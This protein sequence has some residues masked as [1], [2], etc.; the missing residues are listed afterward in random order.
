MTQEKLDAL[1]DYLIQE[2]DKPG[3]TLNLDNEKEAANFIDFLKDTTSITARDVNRAM[4][5]LRLQGKAAT[6][7]KLRAELGATTKQPR[8]KIGRWIAKK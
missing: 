2:L 1:K 3:K 6:I 5:M 4:E 8:N 7:D